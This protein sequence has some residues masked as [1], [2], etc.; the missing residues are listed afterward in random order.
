MKY[1]INVSAICMDQANLEVD[2]RT[3]ANAAVDW[4]HI[5]VMDG[6]FV[7][8]YGMYPEQVRR[9]HRRVPEGDGDAAHAR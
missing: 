7:P 2:A 9:H 1:D 6:H 5:D 3:V 4:L 8:R